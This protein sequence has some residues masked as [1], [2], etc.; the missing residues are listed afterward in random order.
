MND[1]LLGGGFL[2]EGRGMD[3]LQAVQRM[4]LYAHSLHRAPRVANVGSPNKLTADLLTAQHKSPAAP[5]FIFIGCVHFKSIRR[6][7]F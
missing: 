6:S 5:L 2:C 3:S 7:T 1:L 4:W